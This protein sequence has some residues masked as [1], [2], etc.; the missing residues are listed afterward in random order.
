MTNMHPKP[1]IAIGYEALPA[2]GN[3]HA[4]LV[5]H[6]WWGLNDECR[7]FC[8]RLAQAGYVVVAPDLWGGTVATTISEAELLINHEQTNQAAMLQAATDALAYLQTHP[9]VRD[10]GIA[11]I[12]FSMGAAY[13]LTLAGTQPKVRAVVLYYGSNDVDLSASQAAFLGH[14]AE[15]DPYEPTEWITQLEESI[16]AAGRSVQFH[17]YQGTGHW[18]CESDRSDA[19]SAVDAEQAWQRTLAFLDQQLRA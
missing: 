3:G 13:A 10:A 12:G 14:F 7:S 15:N 18:F 2:A 9:A 16:R 1:P 19:Y 8:N 4:V 17:H 5:L 11:V 6:A